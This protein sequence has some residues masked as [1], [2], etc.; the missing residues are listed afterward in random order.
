MSQHTVVTP[1][2]PVSLLASAA[3]FRL[4]EPFAS[5]IIHPMN[6]SQLSGSE[7]DTM[8]E[9]EV[10]PCP[11]V[12]VSHDGQCQ[13]CHRIGTTSIPLRLHL[14]EGGKF[15]RHNLS[16]LTKRDSYVLCSN[17]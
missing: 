4:V 13:N 12:G 10:W 9:E 15:T 14:L 5:H 7:D 1:Q 6:Q 8:M 3:P 16:L 2:I 11:V 17:C